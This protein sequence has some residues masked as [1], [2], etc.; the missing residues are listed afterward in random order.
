MSLPH[1]LV[2]S[3]HFQAKKHSP[4]TGI[5]VDRQIASLKQAGVRI[6]TFDIG[7]SHSPIR[8]LY[9][10]LELR[11]RVRQASPDLV[12][13]QYGTIVG[14]LT[15]FAG[16]PAVI[17]FCGGDLQPGA[18]VS[19][20]RLIVGFLLSNLAAL[21]AEG[22]ICKS[23]QLRQALWWRKSLAVVIPSGVD[24][25]LFSP[26]PQNEARKELGWH[27]E[28]PVAIV[29]VGEDPKGK[30]IDL[31]HAAMKFVREQIPNA[32]LHVISKVEP[33]RIPVYFRA[34]DVLLCTSI[35]E[36][37]PNVV[38]EALACN[39]P[40]VSTPVGDVSE[41]LAGVYPSGVVSRDPREFGEAITKILLSRQRSNGRERIMDLG[42]D[43]VAGQV[44]A[45]YQSVLRV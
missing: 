40:V 15:A 13:G 23:E 29:N 38:K 20:L 8:I 6:S 33:I 2:I 3:N 41:R 16:R 28:T 44:I 19:S 35:T 36:G 24:L 7:T 22:L 4:S 30:G 5:F 9:K 21:R 10:W 1:V 31:A 25:N 34:A 17:S 39:L 42:L 45:V 18:S 37:S 27:L 14:L 11:R 32:E 26:G 12:H 43:Q